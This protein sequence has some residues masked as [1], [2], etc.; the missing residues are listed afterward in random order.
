M[1]S[2]TFGKQTVAAE[3]VET[4]AADARLFLLGLVIP[5]VAIIVAD[6]YDAGFAWCLPVSGCSRCWT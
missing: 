2:F 6:A 3:I 5:A 1:Q 4:V